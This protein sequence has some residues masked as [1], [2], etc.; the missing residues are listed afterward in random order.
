M[1]AENVLA[2]TVTDERAAPTG[3]ITLDD[4]RRVARRPS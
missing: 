1:L 4:I 3:I 2:L